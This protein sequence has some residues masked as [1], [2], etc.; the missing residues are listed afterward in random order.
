MLKEKARNGNISKN[1]TS[2]KNFPLYM[3][4][5]IR[6]SNSSAAAAT[7]AVWHD[8]VV[9]LDAYMRTFAVPKNET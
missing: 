6:V 8:G 9:M 4:T 3:Y 1:T 5:N 2:T 7:A